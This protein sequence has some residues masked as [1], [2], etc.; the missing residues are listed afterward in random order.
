MDVTETVNLHTEIF[1]RKFLIP[2]LAALL[3][4][5]AAVT[6]PGCA[7]LGA[8]QQEACDGSVARIR[9]CG[10]LLVG[11]TGDYH[12]L[13]FLE[14]DGSY[15]GFG[16][17]LAGAIAEELGVDVRFVP[18][19]WPT[20]SSDV[21]ADPQKFDLAIGGITITEQRRKTMLMSE[22]YL[23]NGKTILCR[24]ADAGR[25][26]S[27]EDLNRPDVRVMVNPG[28]TNQLFAAENL[29][30]ATISVHRNN[31]EIPRLV[32][33]G[34]ADVMITEVTEAPYYTGTDDRLAAPL[35]DKPFTRGMIGVLMRK[36]QDGLMEIVNGVIER[37]KK[38][39][40]LRE[41]HERYGLVYSLPEGGD[42]K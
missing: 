23:A 28:G 11:T 35:I 17:E 2:I 25:F 22:G 1:R 32:A 10:A 3:L 4:A 30:N 37:M 21:T 29:P 33:E 8:C 6:V 26:Q 34:A 15:S 36:G 31:L 20:L 39:G 16:I 9:R 24:R 42:I 18:T 41:L 5:G 27:L 13:T 38:D 7:S 12:P 40:S 14:P 19:S